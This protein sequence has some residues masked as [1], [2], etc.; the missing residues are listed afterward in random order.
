[1]SMRIEE[2]SSRSNPLSRPESTDPGFTLVEILVVIGII[3]MLMV[4][5]TPSLRNAILGG[6]EAETTG[7]ATTLQTMILGYEDIHGTVPPDDGSRIGNRQNDWELGTDNGKN[8]GIES[9]VLHLANTPKAGSL[10]EHSGWFSNTDGDMLPKEIPGLG[11][12]DRIEIVDAWG[13]PFAY[14]TGKVG[15]GYAGKETIL[16]PEIADEPGFEMTARPVKDDAGVYVNPRGFQ[17]I[18]AGADKEF[19]TEDDLVYPRR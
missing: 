18:S 6:Q 14:F 11:R 15:S 13:T 4:A 7:R 2:P 3:S 19:G 12:K 16:G 8:S 10:D 17:L 9:L 1:M 5:L